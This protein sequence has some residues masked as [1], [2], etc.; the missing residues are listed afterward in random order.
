MSFWGVILG[1]FWSY[2]GLF[3]GCCVCARVCVCVCVRFGVFLGSFFASF[4]ASIFDRFLSDLGVV[5]GG[6]WEAFG[7]SNRSFL[8]SIF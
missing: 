8:A 5:L 6:F 1:S 4:F 7:R 2:V 3:F